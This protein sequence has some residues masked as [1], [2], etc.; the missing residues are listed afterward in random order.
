LYSAIALAAIFRELTFE[1]QIWKFLIEK[2]PSSKTISKKKKNGGQLDE[3]E[4]RGGVPG[5]WHPKPVPVAMSRCCRRTVAC[6]PTKERVG[7]GYQVNGALNPLLLQRA[8]AA[9]G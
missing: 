8:G 7:E 1:H 2:S 3:R 4:G 6:N 5:G 9:G